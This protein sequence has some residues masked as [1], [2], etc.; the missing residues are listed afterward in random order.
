MK[1]II[2]LTENDLLKIVKKVIEEQSIRDI[3]VK[4]F[5]DAERYN[6]T[7]KF[8]DNTAVSFRGP[9]GRQKT[10]GTSPKTK[11]PLMK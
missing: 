6:N 2:K 10:T 5:M 4:K 7:Q 9:D 8:V 11:K 1:K 3:D